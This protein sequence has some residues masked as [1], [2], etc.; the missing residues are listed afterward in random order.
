MSTEFPPETAEGW[1]VLHELY[2]I[3]WQSIKRG[4]AGKLRAEVQE[5]SEWLAGRETLSDDGQSAAFSMLGHKGQ[6]MLLHFAPSFDLCGELEK[7]FL[8]TD[9]ARHFRLSNSYVSIVE[10]GMYTVSKKAVESLTA[11]GLEPHSAEWR[12]EFDAMISP[13]RANLSE[14]CFTEIPEKKY[15]CFYPMSKRRGEV[16]NWYKE[17]IDRRADL[18]MEHG[19]TG[20]RYADRV[21]QIIS[22][23]IGF[24]DWEWGVDLFSDEPLAFKQLVYEMRFDEATSL[25]G[26]FGPFYFGMRLPASKWSDFFVS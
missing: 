26:E 12:A 3:D 11:K 15:F 20:R 23:S 6:F 24:D 7:Q 21:S 19:I 1:S 5:V 4:D 22:G 16:N 25:Y 13:H 9:F 14:R 10:L 8:R 18:M 2:E 17:K